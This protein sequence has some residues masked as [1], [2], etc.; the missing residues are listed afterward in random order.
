MFLVFL[1]FYK[2]SKIKTH[3]NSYLSINI[4]ILESLDRKVRNLTYSKEV[5]L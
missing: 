4:Y 1:S 3:I 5:I 2:P